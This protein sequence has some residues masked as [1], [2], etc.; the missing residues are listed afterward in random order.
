V[1]W[2][3]GFVSAPGSAAVD[4]GVAASELAGVAP[5]AAES[6]RALSRGASFVVHAASKR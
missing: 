1:Y 5:A 2:S 6:A 3:I 4:G